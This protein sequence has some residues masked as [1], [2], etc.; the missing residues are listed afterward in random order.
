[1]A[2]VWAR[3]EFVVQGYE[4]IKR[5]KRFSKRTEYVKKPIKY[6]TSVE[7]ICDETRVND[8]IEEKIKEELEE[9]K[10]WDNDFRGEVFYRK[11]CKPAELYSYPD[12]KEFEMEIEYIRDWKMKKIMKELDGNQFAILC[13]ELG[14]SAGEAAT[15]I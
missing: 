6:L 15:K 13:K 14:I 7:A 4:E 12:G 1:M 10:G 3:Q 5:K 2:L 11:Y 8:I 9:A